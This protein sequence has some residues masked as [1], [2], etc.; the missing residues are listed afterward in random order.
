MKDGFKSRNRGKEDHSVK[1]REIRT[2]TS[3]TIVQTGK[4]GSVREFELNEQRNTSYPGALSSISLPPVSLHRTAQWDYCHHPY[5]PRF[6]GTHKPSRQDRKRN[7][8]SFF[9]PHKTVSE[10]SY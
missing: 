4:E 3:V 9:K 1:P 5:S 8:A 10:I 2:G 6:E 7:P